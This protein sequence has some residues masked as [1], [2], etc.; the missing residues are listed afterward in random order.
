MPPKDWPT[1]PNEIQRAIEEA[2]Q[3]FVRKGLLVDSGQRRWSERTGRLFPVS[4]HETN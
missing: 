3:E 4:T 1:D 2:I